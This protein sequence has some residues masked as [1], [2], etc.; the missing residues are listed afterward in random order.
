MSGVVDLDDTE[1]VCDVATEDFRVGRGSVEIVVEP[2][3]FGPAG[4][5]G[6]VMDE[7]RLGARRLAPESVTVPDSSCCQY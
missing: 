4:T 2:E 3:N 6:L 1:Y 7:M 5:L